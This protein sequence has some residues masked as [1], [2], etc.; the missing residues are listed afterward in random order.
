V[1]PRFLADTSAW[2]R[3]GQIADRWAELLDLDEIALCLPI[4]LELLYSSRGSRDYAALAEDLRGLTNLPIDAE[5]ES[6]ALRSQP[7][8]ARG[9]HHRGPTPTDLLIAAVAEAHSVTLLHYDRHFDLIAD[10]TGQR[11]EW[12]AARGTLN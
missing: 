5:V 4:R 9:G 2:T 6:A 10:A 3:S 1:A 7:A 12:I 8:L 11:A